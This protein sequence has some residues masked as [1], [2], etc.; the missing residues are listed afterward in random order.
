MATKTVS[1]LLLTLLTLTA[2]PNGQANPN[3]TAPSPLEVYTMSGD[4]TS[5]SVV[6]W[7]RCTEAGSME[8]AILKGAE[9]RVD[10]SSQNNMT[11]ERVYNTS[12]S[13]ATDFTG[14][15][16]V[17]QLAPK[18]MYI[19]AVT[20]K[21]QTTVTS[22]PANFK[23]APEPSDNAAVDFVWIADIAGQ[24]WGINNDISVT[25]VNEARFNGSTVKGGY[26]FAEVASLMKPDFVVFTGDTIYADGR[27][28]ASKQRNVVAA[29]GQVV[30]SSPWNNAYIKDFLANTV[31]EFRQNWLYNHFDA[32]YNTLTRTAAAYVEWDDHEVTNNWYPGEA[33][34]RPGSLPADTLAARGR[35]AFYEYNPITPNSSI[36]RSFK[37]GKHLEMFL[38]DMRTYRGPNPD[39][40]STTLVEMFGQEQFN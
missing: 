9:E 18:T 15:V 40:N 22:K 8:V 3:F 5:S 20:C 38:V 4:V 11:M 16:V 28:P 24:G 21:G 35:Q 23:T 17:Q 13:M 7:A 10:D 37:Q 26:L 33:E 31:E 2:S 14:K 36:Y 1:C 32:K 25:L 27:I 6:I 12:V 29:N 30:D 19:Y 34:P 39:N